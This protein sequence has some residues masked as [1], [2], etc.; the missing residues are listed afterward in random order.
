MMTVQ[1]TPQGLQLQAGTDRL[2]VSYQEDDWL[3][4]LEEFADDRGVIEVLVDGVLQDFD[5]WF[6]ELL[7]SWLTTLN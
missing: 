1:R 6:C 7:K 4:R 3:D 5:E 2:T